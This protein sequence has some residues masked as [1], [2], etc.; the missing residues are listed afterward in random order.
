LLLPAALSPAHS[1]ER[2]ELFTHH[3]FQYHA[4]GTAGQ[5][6]QMVPKLVLLGQSWSRLP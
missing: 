5:F 2:V 3:V 1:D 4:N 6:T